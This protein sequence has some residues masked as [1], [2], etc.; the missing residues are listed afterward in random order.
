MPYYNNWLVDGQFSG[1]LWNPF[2]PNEVSN[3]GVYKSQDTPGIV[4][5]TSSVFIEGTSYIATKQYF[6]VSAVW[7]FDDNTV[8]FLGYSDWR[9]AYHGTLTN[10]SGCI[11]FSPGSSNCIETDTD[12][13]RNNTNSITQEPSA[14]SVAGYLILN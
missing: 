13:I 14:T 1:L 11:S 6:R 4:L 2:Y 10:N 8:Y 3:Y 12:F 5:D 9:V 7:F